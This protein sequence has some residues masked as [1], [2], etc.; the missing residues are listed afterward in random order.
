DA[1]AIDSPPAWAPPDRRRLTETAIWRLGLQLFPTPSE[2]SRSLKGA[3]AWMETGMAAFGAV[4]E[5]GFP[6]FGGASFLSTAFEVFPHAAAVVL[7]GCLPPVGVDLR[8]PGAK[9]AWRASVLARAELDISALK[10]LDQVDAALA[11]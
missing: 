5:L 1:V 4:A 8:H 11:A 3:D 2:A 10:S 9:A 6:L 7:A